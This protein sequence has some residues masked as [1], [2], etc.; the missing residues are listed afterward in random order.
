MHTSEE[1]CFHHIFMDQSNIGVG[2]IIDQIIRE[3]ATQQHN[4]IRS[5]SKY[6]PTVIEKVNLPLRFN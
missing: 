5:V 3:P 4:E 6:R 2:N 1:N